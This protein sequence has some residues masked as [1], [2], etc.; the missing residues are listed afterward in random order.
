MGKD[1]PA[2]GSG[3]VDA[4]VGDD[5]GGLDD[6]VAGGLPGDGEAAPVRVGAGTGGGGV[7]DGG[8]QELVGDQRGVDLL[9]DPGRGAGAQDTAA[10]HGRRQLQVGRFDLPALVVEGDQFA[11]GVAVVIVQGGD[12]PVDAGVPAGAGA[13]RDLAVD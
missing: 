8:A 12:Q 10:E 6:L 2:D 4:G 11:G 7:G 13:D 5:V 3:E 1:V 9:L